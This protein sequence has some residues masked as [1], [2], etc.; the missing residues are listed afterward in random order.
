MKCEAC[1][2]NLPDDAM[3][4]SACGT[5]VAHGHDA[6]R[7]PSEHE[8]ALAAANLLRLR[9]HFAEAEAR[10]IE[11]L[12][13]DPNNVH[14]HS[15]LGDI[16][17][18]QGRREDARQWYQLALDL[19]PKSRADRV[20]LLALRED[21]GG[22]G[23][24][25]EES[26]FA[27]LSSLSWV[28]FVGLALAVFVLGA[29]GA[30]VARRGAKP[31]AP[32]VA[33]APVGSPQLA[34]PSVQRAPGAAMRPQVLEGDLSSEDNGGYSIGVG[35]EGASVA[36]LEVQITDGLAIA[37][38]LS[39][40]AQVVG[41]ILGQ[42]GRT[43]SVVLRY[44]AGETATSDQV[45]AQIAVDA[46]RAAHG[47]L[48]RTEQVSQVDVLVRLVTP[49]LGEYTAFRARADRAKVAQNT[50]VSDPQK[51]LQGFTWYVWTP[52]WRSYHPS[53]LGSVTPQ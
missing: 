44:V 24:D 2:A 49:T 1:A 29:V 37:G 43:A 10:C 53:G 11:V 23:R 17:R 12:R 31:P 34:V 6:A 5:D 7:T 4:C 48:Q 3:F 21:G 13:S 33:V 25:I 20:K 50:S 38:T 42:N 18:D 9:K 26:R 45:E 8:V 30:I 52:A 39:P 14:A 27:G 28:R 16:Y 35:P 15:L 47:T 41:V 40:A 46:M 19:D 36:D 51:A 32:V 22:D